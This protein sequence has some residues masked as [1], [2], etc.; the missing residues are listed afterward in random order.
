MSSGFFEGWRGFGGGGAKKFGPRLRDR[1]GAPARY[2]W[3]SWSAFGTRPRRVPGRE[4]DRATRG[5]RGLARRPSTATRCGRT[6]CCGAVAEAWPP[7]VVPRIPRNPRDTRSMRADSPIGPPLRRDVVDRKP[8]PSFVPG[9]AEI[10]EGATHDLR[11]GAPC[12]RRPRR[13]AVAP[14]RRSGPRRRAGPTGRTEAEW[15]QFG[16]RKKSDRISL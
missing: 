11:G 1:C 5:C 2:S 16:T 9:R 14:R 13:H 4:A 6:G 8:D 3:R 12:R 7:G 15:G 10:Q